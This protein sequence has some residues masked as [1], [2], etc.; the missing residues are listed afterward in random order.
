MLGMYVNSSRVV[1]AIHF[2]P[3]FEIDTG[4]VCPI[5]CCALLSWIHIIHVLF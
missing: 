3:W 5:D 2:P 4:L 1:C